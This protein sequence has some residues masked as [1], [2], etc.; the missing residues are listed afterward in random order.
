MLKKIPVTAVLVGMYI[1]GFEGKWMDHPFWRGRF[2]LTNSDYPH[3]LNAPDISVFARMAA[4][5]D[6]YDAMTSE[7]PYP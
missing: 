1:H 5:C 2:A 6:V 4:V 3:G 7:R